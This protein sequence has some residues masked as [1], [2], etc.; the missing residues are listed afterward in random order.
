MAL[1]SIDNDKDK[2]RFADEDVWLTQQQLTEI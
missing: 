2:V 1:S